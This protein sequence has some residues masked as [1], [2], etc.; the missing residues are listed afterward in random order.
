LQNDDTETKCLKQLFGKK[1]SIWS[2]AIKVCCR[3]RKA[4]W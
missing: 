3:K 4:Q 2:L 1:T